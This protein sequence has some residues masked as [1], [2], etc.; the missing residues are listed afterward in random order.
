MN[1]TY[2]FET[3]I[4]GQ[5]IRCRAFTLEEYI[6]LIAAKSNGTLSSA[7]NELIKNC[8]NAVGLNKQESELLVVKLWAHSI[9]EV[10]HEGSWNCTCGRQI[11]VPLNYTHATIDAPEDLW[12]D[13]DAVRIKFK[14]PKLFD[15]S[16]IAKM[17]S[18]CIEYVVVNGEQIY[19]N[20]LSEQEIEDLYSLITIEDI[21]KIKDML[22]KPTVQ[23]S[24]P[25]TC[26]CG[27]SH[28][29][30]IKGL[31]EFFEIMN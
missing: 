3:R 16:N 22:L 21:T 2:T 20:D 9:G 30:T 8:T 13:L 5:H 6:G 18:S 27:I 14:Y 23:L 25:I 29:H 15:D 11:P 24:V 1:I 4:S 17:I 31:K 10:N 26:E 19:P 12:Y 28:I 7:I